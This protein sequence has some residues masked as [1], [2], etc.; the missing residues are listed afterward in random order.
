MTR[1]EQVIVFAAVALIDRA[2][3]SLI[4]GLEPLSTPEERE[5][6]WAA[7]DALASGKQTVLLFTTPGLPSSGRRTL[8]VVEDVAVGVGR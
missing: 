2:P 4:S 5:L 3:I 8:S 6:W 1:D 7:I